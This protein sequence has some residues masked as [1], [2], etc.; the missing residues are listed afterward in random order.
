RASRRT[1]ERTHPVSLSGVKRTRHFALRMSAFDP[2]RTFTPS[3]TIGVNAKTRPE[4][5]NGTLLAPPFRLARL[6]FQLFYR[7]PFYCL[8]AIRLYLVAARFG[9]VE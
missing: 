4:D 5:Q 8:T 9:D 2:K 3:T 7:L 1:F 6:P